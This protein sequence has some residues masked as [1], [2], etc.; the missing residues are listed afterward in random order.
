MRDEKDIINLF[1]YLLS[2][3]FPEVFESAVREY[4]YYVSLLQH[5]KKKKVG[6]F[7]LGNILWGFLGINTK[8]ESGHLKDPH[9]LWK[10]PCN[11]LFNPHDLRE[12]PIL[13]Y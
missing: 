10:M 4:G 6:L 12:A 8:R 3:F 7:F 1:T 5:N 2:C 13:F 11:M 9:H